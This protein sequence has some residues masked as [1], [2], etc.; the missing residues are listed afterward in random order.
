MDTITPQGQW[1]GGIKQTYSEP[2]ANKCKMLLEF[3]KA[4]VGDEFG[5]N[6]IGGK[7]AGRKINSYSAFPKYFQLS[8]Y[9][10][11]EAAMYYSW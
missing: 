9:K 6:F 3:R 10:S 4:C 1:G 2:H 8:F 5:T 7:F 11:S